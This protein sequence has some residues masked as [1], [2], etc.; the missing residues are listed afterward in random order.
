MRPKGDQQD[1]DILFYESF[2]YKSHFKKIITEL[3]LKW[4][5]DWDRFNY[6]TQ[7]VKRGVF[8][9][10]LK[11]ITLFDSSTTLNE[12]PDTYKIAFVAFFFSFS[13][14]AFFFKE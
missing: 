8:G 12:S 6:F 1:H 14:F 7:L 13:Y 4:N 9:F 2:S 10:D 5:N 3:G 11:A